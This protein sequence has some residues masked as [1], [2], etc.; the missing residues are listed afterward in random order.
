[1]SVWLL[2]SGSVGTTRNNINCAGYLQREF[3]CVSAALLLLL[4]LNGDSQ[5]WAEAQL[6]IEN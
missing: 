6:R 4:M 1:L 5:V 3:A 2:L